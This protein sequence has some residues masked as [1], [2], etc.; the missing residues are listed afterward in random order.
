MKETETITHPIKIKVKGVDKNIRIDF[1]QSLF[2]EVSDIA[3]LFTKNERF[4]KEVMSM[5]EDC[6]AEA[7]VFDNKVI[8]LKFSGC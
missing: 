5:N 7:I 6:V 4:L 3:N 2:Q 8:G 1:P